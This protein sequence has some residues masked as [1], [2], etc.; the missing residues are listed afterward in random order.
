[1]RED[2]LA[3]F[4]VKCQMSPTGTFSDHL[5]Y[6]KAYE[7]WLDAYHRGTDRQFCNQNFV[8]NASMNMIFGIRCFLLFGLDV[9]FG[10]TLKGQF[11]CSQQIL[12]QL[13]KLGFL[14]KTEGATSLANLNQ[15]AKSWSLIKL[16]ILAGSYPSL[17]Y[18]DHNRGRVRTKWDRRFLFIRVVSLRA[19]ICVETKTST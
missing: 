14:C 3:A 2:R 7:G 10:P 15:N 11:R 16:A 5:V 13:H 6:V 19:Q 8:S 18:V 12:D 9:F 4:A 17:A 1:M